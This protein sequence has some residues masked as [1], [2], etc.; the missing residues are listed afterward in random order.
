MSQSRERA[1]GEEVCPSRKNAETAYSLP[2][3]PET[4]DP[5]T[6]I[7]KRMEV[8]S[9]HCRAEVH[10][11]DVDQALLPLEAPGK[12]LFLFGLW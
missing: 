6:S 11:Q 8:Y 7:P 5:Q 1:Q 12:N 10:S 9:Q 3:I 4:H 2:V